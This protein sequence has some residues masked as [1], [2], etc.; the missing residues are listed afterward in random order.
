M[1]SNKASSSPTNQPSGA[2][3]DDW[4]TMGKPKKPSSTSTANSLDK[5]TSAV[6]SL[7][8][9]KSKGKSQKKRSVEQLPV[10]KAVDELAGDMLIDDHHDD[11]NEEVNRVEKNN[12]KQQLIKKIK[13]LKKKCKDVE[14]LRE[15]EKSK[16]LDKEQKEKVSKADQFT[17]ELAKL[18][19]KLDQIN[20]KK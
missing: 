5:A 2:V 14:T 19:A 6:K 12:E 9:D 18:Q 3:A 1:A 11:D 17:K 4:V 8:L 10:S 13:T 20:A 15:L 7:S 16:T